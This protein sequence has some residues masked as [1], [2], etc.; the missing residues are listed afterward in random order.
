MKRSERHRLKENELSETLRHTVEGLS[1]YGRVLLAGI[2]LAA[3]VLAAAGGYWGWRSRTEGRARG[4][5]SAA[6]TIAEAQVVA[7]PA[8]APGAAGDQKPPAQPPGT[9][10]SAR[11]RSE[12]LLPKVMEVATGYPSTQA[13]LAAR[14][15]AAGTLAALGRTDE[16]IARFQE[17][18]AAGGAGSFYG[19]MAELGIIDAEIGAA[20]YDRAIAACQQLINRKDDQ[21]PLDGLLEQLGRA[22]VG[23][24]KTA[25]ATQTFNRLTKEFSGSPYADEARRQLDSLLAAP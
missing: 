24:G 25:E 21:L 10:P 5:L 7:P 19:R 3:V 4:L 15:Y 16:A 23:A 2:V 14:Y 8:P 20:R 22:Y 13:G 18:I 11:A 17:V 9:Y 6:L 12:A 1:Q